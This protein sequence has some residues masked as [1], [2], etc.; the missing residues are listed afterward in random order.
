LDAFGKIAADVLF[1]SR[2]EVGELAEPRVA[3]R[4]VSS[5]MP[6][7]QNPVLSVLVRSA[8][9][10]APGL[11]AQLHLAAANFNDER[12]D[13]AWHTEWPALRQLLALALGAAGHVRELAEGLKVFPDAMRRNLDLAGPLLLAEGVGAAV[14]P[15]LEDKDGLNGKQQLQAVVDQTLQA[16][17][18]EQAATYRKLLREAV[19]A[20]VLPDVRL[21]EL[22]NPAGY[23]GEAAEISRRILAAYPDFANSPADT[24][25]NGASRG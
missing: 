24:D 1:L 23:L 7:K 13:G 10:Q 17:P 3:G 16:P 18:A 14:A 8:A 9:L 12:P 11:A 2:P 15:L 22:L 6:Q 19:P 5:A 4:G 20:S 25:A 21:E